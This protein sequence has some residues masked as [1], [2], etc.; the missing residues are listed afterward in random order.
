MNIQKLNC[1]KTVLFKL[2]RYKR[3]FLSLICEIFIP[4]TESW[5]HAAD[6][7][8]KIPREFCLCAWVVRHE[9]QPS[10]SAHSENNLTKSGVKKSE[11]DSVTAGQIIDLPDYLM[12]SKALKSTF[13]LIAF[14]LVAGIWICARFAL[15]TRWACCAAA[16]L[17]AW[18]RIAASILWSHQCESQY[19]TY[20]FCVL[21]KPLS[22]QN[23][24]KLSRVLQNTTR[25][26][27]VG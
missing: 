2:S 23:K 27:V 24:L 8:Y 5:I 11:S 15:L 1:I 9:K 19:F 16:A 25:R 13:N 3:E 6:V 18:W 17:V 22:L 21:S 26:E 4:Y 20:H 14:G 7:E 10:V 12:D